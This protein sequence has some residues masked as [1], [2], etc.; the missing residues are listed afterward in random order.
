[1]KSDNKERLDVLLVKKRLFS[2]RQRAK[3]AI[4]RGFV[5]VCG[6]KCV[7]PAKKVP[8]NAKI[9]IS[10][11]Q[12]HYESGCELHHE[13]PAANE[14][15]ECLPVDVPRGYWKLKEIDE[16]FDLI[17]RDIVVDLGSSAGGFLIYA[18]EKARKV[19]GIEYSREFERILRRIEA[20]R[21]N[22]RVFIDD[23]FKFDLRKIEEDAVDVILN[24]LTLDFASSITALR[25]FLP[26]LKHKGKVLFVHKGIESAEKRVMS[27][28]EIAGLKV[29]S[30]LRSNAKKEVYYLLTL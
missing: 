22:V 2:S 27:E 30:R 13:F 20:E 11:D 7:K 1:M 12:F 28:F 14:M 24:D 3:E 21:N 25:R 15:S 8:L 6:E 19:Y 18:S 16:R 23:V 5:T 9:E 10:Y 17:K 29:I 4:K 26:K